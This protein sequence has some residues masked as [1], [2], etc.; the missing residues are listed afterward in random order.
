MHYNILQMSEYFVVPVFHHGGKFVRDSGG[1]MSYMDGKVKRFPPMDL[2]YVNFFDL[3][4]LF[5]ELGY[6]EYK[7]MYSIVQFPMM[8]RGGQ[9]L[10]HIM[11]TLSMVKWS[12]R[13]DRCFLQWM[14]SNKL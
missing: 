6:V 8:M 7:E 3:V 4:V 12:L 1:Y 11:K 5:K 13:L 2:D 9:H 14:Y 10:T